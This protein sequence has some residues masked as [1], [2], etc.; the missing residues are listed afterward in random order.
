MS[1][2]DWKGVGQFLKVIVDLVTIVKDTMSQMKVGLEILGWLIGEG[3]SVF[4]EWLNGLG[5]KYLASLVIDFDVGPSAPKDLSI[6]PESGQIAS[7]VRGKKSL[8]EIKVRLH[9]DSGQEGGGWIGG[10]NLKLKLEGQ[11]V[12]G[13]QLLD[14]YLAHT[15]LIPEDWKTKGW[16][17]F[18]GT[19]Y[20]AENGRLCV[21]CLHWFG[22]RW[23]SR[24]FRLDDDWND[25]NPAAV[26]AS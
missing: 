11:E 12:Y 2:L 4:V 10:Y 13:A 26:S 8:S 14:F 18:W 17:F 1:K 16:I 24:C 5:L 21:R 23:V 25:L 15:E 22:T 6:A 3:K 7:R 19:I 9:L 20:R